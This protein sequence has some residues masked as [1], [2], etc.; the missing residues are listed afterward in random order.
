MRNLFVSFRKILT[1]RGFRLCVGMTVVLLFSAEVY[2]DGATQSRYSVFR[3]ITDI[4]SEEFASNYMLCDIMVIGNARFGWLSMFAPILAG[5]CFVPQMCAEC[6]ENAVRF[7]IFRSSKLKFS[8][9]QF[10]SGIISGGTA[11]A[12]GFII[13]GGAVFLLF[14][15]V[16]EMAEYEMF[17]LE[18]AEFCFPKN[19]LEAWLFGAFW[20][21]PAMFLTS[22]MS[23]KYLIL[24]IPFFVKYALTQ[25]VQK[26]SQNAAANFE[27]VDEATLKFTNIVHPDGLLYISNPAERLPKALFFSIIAAVLFGA[28]LIIS[29][30]RGDCG[31]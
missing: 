14:P 15:S 9:T 5:F 13:F 23:N 18:G 29:R 22:V 3:V 11:I 30:K 20:S 28:Y 21:I 17:F 7:Q 6:E 25:T 8:V 16:S 19:I 27:G 10:L 12:L 2:T 4:P 1:S 24:C 26:L 31:A